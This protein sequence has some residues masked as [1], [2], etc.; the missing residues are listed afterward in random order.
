MTDQ[1]HAA[2]QQIVIS[3]LIP[4]NASP[5]EPLPR[6]NRLLIAARAARS[7]G[8]GVMVADW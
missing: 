2:D 5:G 7:I 6:T 1:E 3:S 4:W 8:Q